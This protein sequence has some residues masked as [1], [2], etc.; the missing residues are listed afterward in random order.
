M[1]LDALFFATAASAAVCGKRCSPSDKCFR[2]LGEIP[3][4]GE[5]FCSSLLSLDATTTVAVVETVASS[6]TIIETVTSVET[7][8]VATTTG[9]VFLEEHLSDMV[10]PNERD[11]AMLPPSP[12]LSAAR[13]RPRLAPPASQAFAATRLA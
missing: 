1:K 11:I 12:S 4:V 5:A 8:N 3:E 2:A 9:C 13:S 10:E 7:V 6:K